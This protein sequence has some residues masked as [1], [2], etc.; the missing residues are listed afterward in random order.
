[1]LKKISA[2]IIFML[3]IG[4]A[5]P[6][7]LG[8]NTI[9]LN[10]IIVPDDYSS[11]Q[12]AINNANKGDTIFVRNGTYYENLIVDKS[13]IL[14]G[15]N[16]ETTI[17][18]GNGIGSV[19]VLTA[20]Y[21]TISSFT[22]TNSGFELP[23]PPSYYG[24]LIESSYNT[25]SD[26]IISNNM[27]GIECASSGYNTISN[28]S[29]INDG[30]NIHG[31]YT[32]NYI[33]TIYNNTVNGKPYYYF[34]NKNNFTIPSDAGGVFLFRCNDVMISGLN[35]D[36]TETAIKLAECSNCII[37]NSNISNIDAIGIHIDTSN[38]II[39]Q[40]NQIID[41]LSYGLLLTGCY[42]DEIRDNVITGDIWVGIALPQFCQYNNI[43]GNLIDIE[44]SHTILEH[45]NTGIWFHTYCFNNNI[46][47]NVIRGCQIGLWMGRSHLN[48]IKR[49]LFENCHVG[50]SSNENTKDI[51][52]N[53]FNH[54]S[55]PVPLTAR[56]AGIYLIETGEN[57]ISF[58]TITN[59][60]V[61]II[62]YRSWFDTIQF[63][64]IEDST[65][66]FDFITLLSTGYYP[67]NYWGAS[68]TGPIF[69]CNR[70]FC[71]I[72]WSPIRI[73]EAP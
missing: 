44:S 48:N 14:K 70:F 15:E 46:I 11:I 28:N 38:G 47:E 54:K 31:Y 45:P 27:N 36:S 8:N 17:I 56:G 22:I 13:I 73:S 32:S 43:T 58:N 66:G 33:H 52:F 16:R 59:N 53:W 35:I 34:Y 21:T 10:E 37:Q 41:T 9:I 1:M 71:L 30:I 49:N 72:P 55:N 61:G 18:D 2:I 20:D 42:Y 12:E 68:I 51:E 62:S 40:N 3:L 60:D 23:P 5:F 24:I 7:V 63:N 19:L 6:L 4:S 69:K 39:I 25:I 26:N 57:E 64:N 50:T 67:F 65:T 29:L